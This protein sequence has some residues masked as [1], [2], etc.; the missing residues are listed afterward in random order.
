MPRVETTDAVPLQVDVQQLGGEAKDLPSGWV[1]ALMVEKSD[2][3]GIPLRS[4]PAA[5]YWS[6]AI[7]ATASTPWPITSPTTTATVP[8]SSAM[9][10]YQ[11]PPMP[12]AATAGS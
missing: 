3:S 1:M 10:S 11:S 12:T 9:T 7:T 4:S 8:S 2:T 6:W 5:R